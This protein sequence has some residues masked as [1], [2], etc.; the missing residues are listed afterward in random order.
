MKK[1]VSLALGL[2]LV[3]ALGMPVVAIEGEETASPEASVQAETEAPVASPVV[4]DPDTPNIIVNDAAITMGVPAHIYDDTTYAS[5]YP[6]IKALYPEAT[7]TW[8]NGQAV[9]TA[10]GLEV[11]L[12][13]TQPYMIVNGHY[14]YLPDGYKVSDHI[15]TVPVRIL[16]AAL[17]ANLAW[18]PVGNNV[19]ITA[20]S[21]PIAPAEEAY[22]ADDLYW[23]S[24]IINAESGNQPLSGKIA[25]GN[26]V[27]NRVANSTFP[28]TVY[29]VVFQPGQFTPAANGTVYAEP[30]AESVIAAK[31]CLDGANV[32]GNAL[33]FFNYHTAGGCWAAKNR[34][35]VMTI[36]DH[37]FH[38]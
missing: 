19:V 5:Y 22:N 29:S 31:L 10:P 30:N 4:A 9:V 24:H 1:F 15:I 23:L 26:V 8:E 7:A 11:R 38:G 17:G 14:L 6:I 27:L 37:A 34:P 33:F 18:D 2:S 35:Y 16:C 21:G 36:G 3:F 28:N 25:V 13:I 20:G 12:P 32:A